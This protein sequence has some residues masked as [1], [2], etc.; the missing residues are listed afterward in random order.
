M[1]TESDKGGMDYYLLPA[2]G[3]WANY[4]TLSFLV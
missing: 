3:L 4:L 1:V 2:V